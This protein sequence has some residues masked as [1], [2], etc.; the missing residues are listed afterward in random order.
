MPKF[1]PGD[2]VRLTRHAIDNG[3]GYYSIHGIVESATDWSVSIRFPG[4]N[5]DVRYPAHLWEHDPAD[6]IG[7]AEWLEQR[8]YDA[9]FARE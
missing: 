4:V 7:S 1:K 5:H 9:A 8:A 2:R 6:I 3:Y